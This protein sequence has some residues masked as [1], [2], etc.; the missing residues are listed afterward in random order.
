MGKLHGMDRRFAVFEIDWLWANFEDLRCLP[1]G[2][3]GYALVAGN[4]AVD[5]AERR[6]AVLVWAASSSAPN[7]MS[8]RFSNQNRSG[9][10]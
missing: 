7:G 9:S 2:C 10:N 8:P 5:G 6:A 3:S 4:R 1:N